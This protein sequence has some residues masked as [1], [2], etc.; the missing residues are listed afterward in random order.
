MPASPLFVFICQT[1]LY[2]QEAAQ[3][4]LLHSLGRA[5]SAHDAPRRAFCD[6]TPPAR[7]WFGSIHLSPLL[8]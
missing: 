7:A 6:G 4:T 3:Q 5:S 2:L 1:T 8:S